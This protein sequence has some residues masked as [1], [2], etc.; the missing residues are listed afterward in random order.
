VPP[1]LKTA[2]L[3][4]VLHGDILGPL[5]DPYLSSK[6]FVE[7]RGEKGDA[8]R[9]QQFLMDYD[10][11]SCYPV[12]AGKLLR[13]WKGQNLDKPN[14]EDRVQLND[15]LDRLEQ[16]L[17]ERYEPSEHG[18]RGGED[19]REH[20]RKGFQGADGLA[21]AG[22]P[23]RSIKSVDQVIDGTM[24]LLMGHTHHIFSA[25]RAS[26]EWHGLVCVIPAVHCA[27]GAVVHCAYGA[28]GAAGRA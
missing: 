16:A 3:H 19:Y 28:V 2:A 13:L 10:M 17:Q 15:L 22:S 23:F 11:R 25:V 5:L 4:T 9:V 27:Y 21:D 24:P 8:F 14:H 12:V 26:G 7:S 20:W 6:A 1:L 18:S